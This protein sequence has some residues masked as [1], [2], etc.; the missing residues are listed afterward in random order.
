MTGNFYFSSQTQTKELSVRQAG[1]LGGLSVLN[2]Y[3][4]AHF[5]KIGKLG[6]I[7]MRAKYPGMAPEWGSK[8]GRPKKPKLY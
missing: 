2:K 4:R 3:G 7:S 8:G 6:Q 1:R 5:M